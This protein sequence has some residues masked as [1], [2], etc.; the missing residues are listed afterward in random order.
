MTVQK[1]KGSNFFIQHFESTYIGACFPV[2][3]TK[4]ELFNTVQFAF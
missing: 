2:V 1:S 4:I 3:A